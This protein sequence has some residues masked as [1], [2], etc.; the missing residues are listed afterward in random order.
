[1]KKF[2]AI[3]IATLV[4]LSSF[5][6]I[7]QVKSTGT[8]SYQKAL[9]PEVKE[10]AYQTAQ[11]KAIESYFAAQGDAAVENFDSLQDKIQTDIEKYITSTTVLNEQDQTGIQKYSI[12]VRVEL[13]TSRLNNLIK[14]NSAI[15]QT[16]AVNGVKSKLVYIFLGREVA[17]AR[18][19]D[20]RVYQRTDTNARVDVSVRNTRQNYSSKEKNSFESETGGST[21]RKSDDVNFKL[22][23]MQKYE[24]SITSVF[25]Q[26]GFDVVDPSMV[27]DDKDFKIAKD[28]IANGNDLSPATKRGFAKKMQENQI[29]YLIL[30]TLDVGLAAQDDATGLQRVGVNVTTRVLNSSLQEIAST[31]IKAVAAV[32][33]NNT[34][35]RDLA[36]K[37]SATE[38]SKEVVSSLNASNI[39]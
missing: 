36:L 3:I 2:I 39:H 34:E 4:P 17:N 1:M 23:P 14:K 12:V 29:Q 37:K 15:G 13:N 10:K 28:D 21:L 11:M 27:I 16:A 24:T 22:L 20:A 32:A 33:P 8:A 19:Y 30:T 25:T 9:T 6:E 18:E 7:V 26:G 35:A 38:A 5:A 31:P